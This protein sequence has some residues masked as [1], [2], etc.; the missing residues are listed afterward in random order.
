MNTQYE[1]LHRSFEEQFWGTKMNLGGDKYSTAELGR[2]KTEMEAFLAD[3]D[4]LKAT[5]AYLKGDVAAGSDE[6]KTLKMLERTFGCYIMES[7]EALKLRKESTE[8]EGALEAG[9]NKMT[10]GATIDGKF[11]E[12]SSVGLR[13]KMR[14]DPSEATRK[15]C[16]EGLRS[17]GEFVTA[18]GFVELVRA[19]NS[20]AREY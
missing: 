9:R 20:M 5:R 4:K 1:H 17:I 16:W 2:T 19:R 7:E 3:E 18:N 13:N 8:I 11:Q 15:A 6:E 14:T 10:L 12:L